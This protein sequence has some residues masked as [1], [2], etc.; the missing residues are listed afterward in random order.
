MRAH[1]ACNAEVTVGTIADAARRSARATVLLLIAGFVCHAQTTERQFLDRYCVGC[2]NQKLKTAG[3]MLDQMDP[4][5][6]DR[7]PAQW[8]KVVRKLRAG[9]MPPSGAA[10]PERAVIATFTSKLETSLDRAAAAKP[11]PGSV[12]VHR[13]NRAEYVNAVRDLLAVEVDGE[14]LLPAD[15]SSEGFDNIADALGVSPA[16]LERY[17]S[18]ATNISRIAVG[19]PSIT[20]T[21]STYRAPGDLSQTEHIEG[22][23]LGTRGGIVIHHTFPLDADYT[24]KIRAR[25]SGL[26][27]GGGAALPDL[28]VTVDGARVTP[29]RGQGSADLRIAIK[30][31]PHAIGVALAKENLA[32]VDDIYASYANNAGVQSV[33][34]TGPINPTGSGDTLSRRKIF[35]CRPESQSD[36]TTCAKRILSSLARHAYRRPVTDADLETLLSFYQKARNTGTFERGVEAALARVLIDPWFIFRFEKEPAGTKPG[37]IYAVSDLELASRLSFFL[38]SSI[39]DDELLN[40]AAQNKLREPAV[41][42]QQVRRMLADPRSD[43]LVNEFRRAVAVPARISKIDAANRDVPEFNDNLRQAFRAR[44]RDVLREHRPRGSQRDRLAECRLHVCQ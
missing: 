40:L 35:T 8:E 7:Q 34:I 21:T 27:V 11:N 29:V 44:D 1:A 18:A 19:D 38:W 30:A 3:L 6:V 28:E 9:M 13:L 37:D 24:F 4:A 31:G 10:R 26:G 17:V 16:L 12:M 2:H 20:A 42:E 33:A 14:T 5:Q 36:E 41:L 43:A 15:D 32:G 23:P 25:S 39:P 22:L